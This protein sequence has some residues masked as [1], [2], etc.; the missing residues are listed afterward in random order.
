MHLVH[1]NL[2]CIYMYMYSTCIRVCVCGE[3]EREGRGREEGKKLV[4]V[5]IIYSVLYLSLQVLH[6]RSS[7]VTLHLSPAHHVGGVAVPLPLVQGSILIG[8][9]GAHC[10]QCLQSQGASLCTSSCTH[11]INLCK[12]MYTHICTCILL[13]KGRCPECPGGDLILF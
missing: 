12:Y 13:C 5:Y 1:C 10:S 4:H 7:Y 11:S 3:R 2:M 9:L 8:S 6:R